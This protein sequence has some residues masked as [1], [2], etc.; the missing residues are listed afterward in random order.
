MVDAA[1]MEK[2]RNAHGFYSENLNRSSYLGVKR[3]RENNI[4]T[5]VKTKEVMGIL[6]KFVK[7]SKG[8]FRFYKRYNQLLKKK[9]PT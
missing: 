3:R 1:S 8:N 9:Y 4:Q 2:M 7:L 5:D 6:N